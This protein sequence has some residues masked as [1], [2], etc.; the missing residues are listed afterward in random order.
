MKTSKEEEE[1]RTCKK[2]GMMAGGTGASYFETSTLNFNGHHCFRPLSRLQV[3]HVFFF[4]MSHTAFCSVVSKLFQL[5][6]VQNEG[7]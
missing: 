3:P 2:V 1:I 5:P 7:N 6:F 4:L